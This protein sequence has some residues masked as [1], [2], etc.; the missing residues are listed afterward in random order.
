[1]HNRGPSNGGFFTAIALKKLPG[2]I[3]LFIGEKLLVLEKFAFV[4]FLTKILRKILTILAHFNLIKVPI[5]KIPNIEYGCWKYTEDEKDITNGDY[6]PGGFIE[7]VSKSKTISF[8]HFTSLGSKMAIK[9]DYERLF[10]SISETN[11]NNIVFVYFG[12]TDWLGHLYGPDS[13]EFNDFLQKLDVF[14]EKWYKKVKENDVN[15][16]FLGDHGMLKVNTDFDIKHYLIDL[17]ESFGLKYYR[18]F[19]LFTDSTIC[20]IYFLKR[21]NKSTKI[22]IAKAMDENTSF[23]VWAAPKYIGKEYGD[24]FIIAKPGVLFFPNNFN[25]KPLKGMH[26]YLCN[27]EN[28]KGMLLCDFSLENLPN[29]ISLKDVTKHL[30]KHL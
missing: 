25:P 11:Q 19:I 30:L 5:Y 24:V 12:L 23:K 4:N 9:D 27:S 17:Y 3:R 13:V 18:D 14:L 20:R 8:K 6:F 26:G 28:N 2:S 29:E 1:L 21:I 10:E 7:E 16:V 22:N 15:V